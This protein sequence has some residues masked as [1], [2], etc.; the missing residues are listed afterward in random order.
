MSLIEIEQ[1]TKTYNPTTIPVEAL[2][3]IDLKI[4]KGELSISKNKGD[5]IYMYATARIQIFIFIC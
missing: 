5:G 1:V 4:E 2:R 3:G